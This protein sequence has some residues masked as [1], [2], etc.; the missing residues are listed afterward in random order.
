MPQRALTKCWFLPVFFVF[1]ISTVKTEDELQ[2]K[3]I[4]DPEAICNDNSR[5]TFYI[6]PGSRKKWIVFFESG[7]FCASYEDCNER[8]LHENSTVLMTSNML[9]DKIT[10]RDL[11]SASRYENPTFYEYTHV[12]VPYC[13]SDLWLGLKTN[14]KEPF[15]F[16]NDS[17]VDNFSFRGHTIFRSVFLDLLQQYNLTDAEEI[18]L[19][20]SSAGGVGVLNHA[21]WV[22]NHVIKSHGLNTKLLSIIDS[23]WFID[24]QGSFEAKV[25]PGFTS[26]ANISSRACMDVSP[27]H[28]CCPSAPCMISRGYYPAS[29]PLLLISSMYDIF[30]FGEV[31]TR[32]EDEGK[33]AID[34]AADYL[35]VINMYGGAMNESLTLTESQASN[36]SFFTPACFQHIYLSMSSLYDENGAFQPSMEITFGTG[37]FRNTIQSG[38]WESVKIEKG[39]NSTSIRDFI[40]T[41][42]KSRDTSIKLIDD[43]IGAQCNPTCP[44]QLLFTD[45]AA[46]WGLTIETIIIV[47]SLV[48]TVICFGLKSIFLFRQYY[49]AWKQ[50][51]YLNDHDSFFTQREL[52]PCRSNE[53][54]SIACLSLSYSVDVAKKMKQE[55]KGDPALKDSVKQTEPIESATSPK[56]E[57]G[58]L[59]DVLEEEDEVFKSDDSSS[60]DSQSSDQENYENPKVHP[61][62]NFGFDSTAEKGIA[63]VRKKENGLAN[64]SV[65]VQFMENNNESDI[66]RGKD[67]NPLKEPLHVDHRTS[68]KVLQQKQILKNVS[69]YFNPGELVAIMGPSGCGKT[70]LLD[71]LTGRR[72]QGNCKVRGSTRTLNVAALFYQIQ[73]V[74]LERLLVFNMQ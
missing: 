74:S 72:T 54:I 58:K 38:N 18:I 49:L 7:G 15:H 11:L 41:W 17:S 48:I 10:G 63:P 69:V 73:L 46:D 59:D 26:F 53:M 44:R 25:R 9:P 22:L 27:G 31:L 6:A 56:H 34:H 66:E 8:Y 14:P 29:V 35:S 2:K 39:D 36:V 52:P 20:G 30:M 60:T 3:Y 13:S 40:G 55:D 68:N 50:K 37:K 71:L 28:T 33:T 32:L 16:V 12:L 24:F 19:S 51:L 5:A 21:D 67:F 42:V 65:H 23:G 61:A 57:Y 45:P 4:S 64:N 62:N 47:L 43:C 70:T 1:C